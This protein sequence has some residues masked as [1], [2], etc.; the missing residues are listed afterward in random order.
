MSTAILGAVIAAGPQNRTAKLVLIALADA[1]NPEGICWLGLKSLQN[2]AHCSERSAQYALRWLETEGWLLRRFRY[3]ESGRQTSNLYQINVA[4]LGLSTRS[5]GEGAKSAPSPAKPQGEGA[6][7]APSPPQ[8]LHPPE[9]AKFAPL[10]PKEGIKGKISEY[11]T[12]TTDLT[13]DMARLIALRL[14][15]YQRHALK[16]SRLVLIDGVS[17]VPKSKTAELLRK[18]VEQLERG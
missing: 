4:K 14:S 11:L 8:N 16:M 12:P 5:Q 13:L 6:K 15:K 7:I 9:G 10:E 3:T 2:A 1:A 17:V 18:A